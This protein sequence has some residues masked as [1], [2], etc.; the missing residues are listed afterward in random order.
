MARVCDEA[1]TKEGTSFGR[2]S[3]RSR[4]QARLPRKCNA[5]N[6]KHLLTADVMC[7][8]SSESPYKYCRLL[9]IIAK[10]EH[11]FLWCWLHSFVSCSSRAQVQAVFCFLT[12][13]RNDRHIASYR[14]L[15]YYNVAIFLSQ[16]GS[17]LWNPKHSSSGLTVE[18]A[19]MLLLH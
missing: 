13:V 14:D 4:T 9:S 11:V 17:A 16:G 19:F 15:I 6:V 18:T 12:A 2:W 7:S 10:L 3:V 1:L 5:R 8:L